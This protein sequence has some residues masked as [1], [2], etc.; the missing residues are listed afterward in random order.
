MDESAPNESKFKANLIT[1][2]DSFLRLYSENQTKLPLI[3]S[4][5]FGGG[6]PSLAS[7]ETFG[8]IIDFL[9]QHYPFDE[10]IEI[11]MEANPTSVEVSKLRAFRDTSINRISLGVQALND[12]DLKY[13]GRAHS[14]NEAK[15]AIRIAQ[16]IFPRV[17]FDLIYARHSQQTPNSWRDELKCAL[18]FGTEHI[19][20]YSLTIEPGTPFDRRRKEG[21]LTPVDDDLEG[22]LY[23]I[24]VEETEKC[25]LLQYEI[26]N[27]ARP[28]RECRHNLN[29]WNS[30]DYIGVGP[31]AASRITINEKRMAYSQV[32]HPTKWMAE[33]SKRG[34]GVAE[35]KTLSFT[36]RMLEVVMVGLRTSHGVLRDVFLRH[37]EGRQMEEIL[38]MC[39]IENLISRGL[40]ILDNY[41]LRATRKGR[42]VLDSFLPYLF[43][44]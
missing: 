29:Y 16:K 11:T 42:Q 32:R 36:E 22:E 33:V 7:P 19:S 24:A 8:A 14:A 6:T 4:I 2:L 20:L 39:E 34:M 41:S 1:E 12:Y 23:E 26:S 13:L 31:G 28:S 27:F 21:K 40:L 18:D 3:T 35:E 9:Q 25:G 30:G 44:D 5:F 37:S 38:N 17:S 15:E 43:R 10:N